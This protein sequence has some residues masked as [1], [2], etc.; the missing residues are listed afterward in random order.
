MRTRGDGWRVPIDVEPTLDE[1]GIVDPAER[2]WMI[3]RLVPH[4]WK[5]LTDPLRLPGGRGR[6]LPRTFILCTRRTEPSRGAERA[7]REPGWR[8]R[9]TRHGP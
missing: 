7:R 6:S 4:P 5:T 9:E 2:R 8:F 3:E 1:F